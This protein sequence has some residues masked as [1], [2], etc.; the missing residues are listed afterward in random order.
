MSSY[1]GFDAL[2]D[3]NY[4]GIPV[5]LPLVPITT[6]IQVLDVTDVDDSDGS[7]AISLPDV[8]PDVNGVVPN[9]TVAVAV[10]RVIRFS[11]YRAAD[12]LSFILHRITT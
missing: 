5:P 9:G 7:G 4:S 11:W 8:T 12:G 1:T 2:I 3:P 6:A 10:G